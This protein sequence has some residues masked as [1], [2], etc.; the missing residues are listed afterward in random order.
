M[1]GSMRSRTNQHEGR[2]GRVALTEPLILAAVIFAACLVGIYT[3]PLGFLANVWPANAIMLG[4][5]LRRPGMAT[6]PG[7][8]AAGIAYMAADL[9]TGAPLFKALLLNGANVM[10]IGAAYAICVKLP[11][12]K[13]RLEHPASL[14]DIAL[15]SAVGAIVAGIVGGLA[16]PVLFGGGVITG[17][18]FW[19]STEFVNYIAILPVILSAPRIRA[20]RPKWNEVRLLISSQL[21]LPALALLLSGI[22]GVAIGGPGAIAFPVPA[23]L[24]CG[25]VY[26]VFPTAVLTLLFALWSLAIIS[27]SYLPGAQGPY[28]ENALISVRLAAA[29]IALGPITLAVVMQSRKELLSRLH[30]LATHDQLTGAASRHAFHETARKLAHENAPVAVLMIDLDHFKAVND[31]Y[32]HAAGDEVLM[33]FAQRVRN[34][35]RPGDAF[36]R[37]GGEEFAVVIPHC[38]KPDAI[39]VSERIREALAGTPIGLSDGRLVKVTASIGLS[40]SPQ[41]GAISVERLLSSADAALYRAKANGRDRVEIAEFPGPVAS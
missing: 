7:W 36:G 10:G 24:W 34:C 14:L 12:A 11:E 6:I 39:R 33:S 17:W 38:P 35:L 37:V 23:L 28:D 8:L 5:L 20:V 31:N 29:L 41:T 30:H 16:N 1:I 13:L 19:F 22:A 4:L 18:T 40:L 2:R 26:P 9:L 32:G 21:A 3:R 27:A 25:L 15:A